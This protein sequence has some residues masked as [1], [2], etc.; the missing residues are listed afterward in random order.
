[1]ELTKNLGALLLLCFGLAFSGRIAAAEAG[2]DLLTPA[3]R[4]WLAQ[5]PEIVLGVG[6]EWAPSV[7][8]NANGR[9]GGF[10]FDHLDLLNRKLGTHIRL[11]VG[12]WHA[13]VEK[14]ETGRLA[15]L[16]LSA[17]V[18]Q[19][20]A[21]FL[22]TQTFN[23]IHYFIYLRT[24]EPAPR[25]GLDGLRGRRIG[26]LKG[27]LYLRN[28]LATHPTIEA[29]PL[30][31]TGALAN[32]LLG[33]EVDAVVDSY[34]LEYWRAS[35]GVLGFAP[36]RM[37]PESQTDLVMS[38]RKDWPELVK[39][40]NKGLAAIT[41]EEMAELYRRWFGQD[42]LSRIAPQA[43]LTAEEQAWLNEHP[44]L[45]VGIDPH[46]APVEFVD[47]AG[48]AQGISITYL[49]NMEIMLGVRFEIAKGLSWS[50]ALRQLKEGMIDLLPAMVATPD[51]R[52]S[53]RFTD[54]YLSFPAAIFSAAAVAYLGD[55]DA[56]KGKVVA[57]V[58]DEAT[59]AWLREQRPELQLLPVEDTREA[60]RKTAAGEAFA[61]VGNLV[62]TSYYIGQSGLNQ[63]KV[64][65][66]TPFVYRLGVGV[67]RDWPMLAG[68]LQKGLDAIPKSERDAIYHDW[69]SIQ[70]QHRIDYGTL[71]TVLTLAGLT[72]FVIVYWNRRLALEVSQRREVETA[73][74][75]AKDAAEQANRAKSVFLAN[76]SHDLR[77]PL[78]AV[79]GFAQLL[80]RHERL[81]DRQRQYVDGIRRGGERLLGLVNDVLDLA[82]VEANRFDLVPVD[83]NSADLWRELAE[84]FRGRAEQKGVGFRIEPAPA[85]PR[86]LSC[87]LKCLRQILVNLLDNA[88]KFTGQG[89]VVLRASFEDD[90]LILGVADTGVGI[91]PE[92]TD[93]IFEP[94]HQ[95]GSA[96]HRALGAGLGLS[97]AKGL[98]ARMGG[99]LAVESAP[100]QGSTFWV[101]IPAR[102]VSL[103]APAKIAE[104]S[105]SRVGGYRRTVGQGSLR[106]LIADDEAEN[107]KILRDLLEPLGFVLAEARTG[108]DCVEMARDWTPDL[109]LMDLRMPD[110]DGLEATR[111]LR[112]I[113]AFRNT[114]IVAVTAAAFAEDRAQALAAGCDAH[115]AKPVSLDALIETL[116]TLLPLEWLYG[117]RSTEASASPARAATEQHREESP[118]GQILVVDDEPENARFLSDLLSEY[119]DRVHVA[120]SG[121]RALEVAREIVR[122]ARLDLILL[123]ILM[124]A[125]IDGIE[126]CRRL[127]AREALRTTPVIFLTGRDDEDI[128][129]RAFDAGGADYVLKPFNA[130]IL[131]AR[132]RAHA[133]LGLLSDH[134]ESALAQRTA[135]LDAANARLR[136]LALEI[137]LIEERER[138]RLAGELHDSPMQK[139]ALAQFQIAAGIRDRDQEAEERLETGLELL[140]EALG[141]LRSLQFELSPP[142]L[143]QEGLAPALEW[144]ATYA[145]QRFGVALSFTAPRSPPSLDQNLAIVLF[146]CARELVYNLAKHAHASAGRIEFDV[147]DGAV[148][149]VVGDDGQGFPPPAASGRPDVRGGYG[150]FSVRERLAYLGGDLSIDSDVGGARV[151]VRV[152]LRS[153]GGEASAD[154]PDVFGIP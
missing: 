116:G 140:R 122:E 32:A 22:F 85:L 59:H 91:P 148:L 75:D 106:I 8:K 113:P 108:R 42:Y 23:A 66:E 35:H 136:Q 17:P 103:P 129:V 123:D 36:M 38:I 7:V 92:Q 90:H 115:F 94:F 81:G 24:G 125:G 16:N 47:E 124:P 64:V 135:A 21:H 51:R 96:N 55:L 2:P 54:P 4:A 46:W 19:R 104:P 63:I 130:R 50:E 118:I 67:R 150:L 74:R 141:E 28:L 101:R 57:V 110:L 62:T 31:G 107:R 44:V 20:K 49:K 97:I 65:G 9:F 13:M 95:V 33:G 34:G 119:A 98:V 117:A 153:G 52:Q 112:A 89:E 3:E 48:I 14:A 128:M 147:R 41:R 76:M 133:Q 138:K 26:Y 37:L 154:P 30:D 6:E 11:E 53:Y 61:F 72:L 71:W 149:L 40:L 79:L 80:E 144:L 87:D 100:G 121:E 86:T 114:P 60:L 131:L 146:Q 83:W 12:P 70:Y 68:I 69:I 142:L 18:E 93:G 15:G 56:L 111:A 143:Y 102:A 109:I 45:R 82:K 152:P 88:V 39:I 5:H 27:I 126:T 145:T 10:A 127:K 1:M 137:S 73:L 132:V 84:M 58:R 134:L 99:S 139:L 78:G 151:S 120:E 25:A 29:L 105:G 77:T 43:A